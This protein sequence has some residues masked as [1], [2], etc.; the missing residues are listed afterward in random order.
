ML[1]GS[2]VVG[3][4]V[5]CEVPARSLGASRL[6]EWKDFCSSFYSSFQCMNVWI[7]LLQFCFAWR[8]RF[9]IISP[10]TY[11]CISYLLVKEWGIHSLSGWVQTAQNIFLSFQSQTLHIC[12]V[13]ARDPPLSRTIWEGSQ[14]WGDVFLDSLQLISV[15]HVVKHSSKAEFQKPCSTWRVG[16]TAALEL[17]NVLYIIVFGSWR[18]NLLMNFWEFTFVL[19]K[20]ILLR[21]VIHWIWSSRQNP[22]FSWVSLVFM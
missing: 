12:I 10:P 11:S 19:L 6:W 2:W 13:A 5:L 4:G 3:E 15:T 8:K 16:T 9:T 14:T 18:G 17:N 20:I 7:T 22:V 1:C 21:L